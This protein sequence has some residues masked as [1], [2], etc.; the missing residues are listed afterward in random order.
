MF[1]NLQPLILASQSPRRKRLLESAGIEFRV[2][3]SEMEEPVIE[4]M[5]PE[6][7]AQRLA[8][9]KTASAAA[10]FPESWVLGADTIVVLEG[11]IFGKPMDAAHA[12]WMLR[13]LSGR[14]HDVIT[15]I[16][17]RKADCEFLRVAPVTTHVRFKSLSDDEIRAYIRTGAPMDKAGAYGIQGTGAF[18]VSSIDGSYTNVVGLPLCEAVEWLLEEEIIAPE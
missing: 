14:N 11:R 12:G 17:L 10:Q 2:F 15:G 13:A 3:P 7:A 9:L 1:R 8:C 5:P 6:E 18:L 16:C 4:G